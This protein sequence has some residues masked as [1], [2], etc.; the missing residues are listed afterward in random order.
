MVKMYFAKTVRYQGTRYVPNTV[1]EVADAD[2]NDLKADGGW[3]IEE[4]QPVELLADVAPEVE[5]A[6]EVEVEPVVEDEQAELEAIV[7]HPRKASKKVG[8]AKGE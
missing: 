5:E 1:F 2:V 7:E 8:K 4:K 3:V 6:P